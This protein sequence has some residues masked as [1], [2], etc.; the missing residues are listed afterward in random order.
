[1]TFGTTLVGFFAL[2]CSHL[3]S[4]PAFS[5]PCSLGHV[6]IVPKPGTFISYTSNHNT[7]D[8]RT[9]EAEMILAL[10]YLG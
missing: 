10:L 3:C 5:H 2:V 4:A 1:M 9:C 7:V 8:A 6:D